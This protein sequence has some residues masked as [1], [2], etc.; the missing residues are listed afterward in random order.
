MESDAALLHKKIDLLTAQ[1]E[2]QGNGN[3]LMLE[4]LEYMTQQFEEQNRRQEGLNELKQDLIPVANPM[5]KLYIDGGM[6]NSD[7]ST[8]VSLVNDEVEIIR[9]GKGDLYYLP[10]CKFI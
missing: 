4:K 2:T 10:V 3:G 5:I 6:L 1:I 7:P 9:Q 8:V